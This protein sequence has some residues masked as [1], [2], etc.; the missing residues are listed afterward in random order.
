MRIA[1]FTDT[2][3]PDV[4]G[5]A[6]TLKR[7]ADHLEKEGYEFK[8]FAPEGSRDTLFSSHIHRFASLPFFLYPECRLALPNMIQAKSELV[9]FNPDIIH[10]AT[11][12]NIGLCGL[13]YAKKLNI[14]VVGSYHT[15]F[16]QYLEYY[17]LQFFSKFLW[18]YMHWFHKPLERIFVPSHETFNQ[19]HHRGFNNLRIWGRGVDCELFHP[20]YDQKEVRDSFQIKEKYILSYVG[21]L[22]PEKDV[23]TLMTIAKQ[24]PEALKKQVRWLIVGDGPSKQDMIKEAP[25]NMT[26]AGYLNGEN[27]AKIYSASDLFV[28]PSPTET[29]GNVVLEALASGTPVV[30]ANS[31]GVKNI[32]QQGK[33]GFLCKP[34]DTNQFIQSI[35][36]LLNHSSLKTEMSL[37]ARQ[38]AITK[39]WDQILGDLLKEYEQVLI[40]PEQIRYA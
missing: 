3:A 21:R 14:P 13:H 1:I 28:F 30:G 39:T 35:Q 32:I 26:F 34:Q 10:I 8:I 37:H 7:F 29:F 11:P 15:D 40:K 23:T 6:R 12:F 17:D 25:E 16:D 22:A 24:L 5:V 33:S 20:R 4:N 2:Y 18:K 36:Q 19:L 38:Y 9:R 27:L 31:G